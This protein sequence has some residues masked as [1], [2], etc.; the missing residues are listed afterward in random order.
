MSIM[1]VS[2]MQYK[3]ILISSLVLSASFH[4]LTNR[5]H[6]CRLCGRIVCSLPVKYPQRPTT[7]SLL[8]VVDPKTERIEEVSEGVDYGVRRR[9][10]ANVPKN[11]KG[12]EDAL[13]D[14]EKFLKGVRI[15]RDCRPVL[16]WVHLC[17]VVPHSLKA[18]YVRRQQYQQE[19]YNTPPF[20]KL[21][22]V[23]IHH[24]LSIW[25]D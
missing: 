3:C 13:T 1:L 18:F 6:H 11:T 24:R 14:E 19:M 23:S 4:P 12:K 20:V 21:Y 25:S 10:T 7:C 15:C 5:K 8:F 9:S 2:A 22:E 17:N 16:L